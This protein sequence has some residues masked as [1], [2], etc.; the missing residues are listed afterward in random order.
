MKS[1]DSI[2][3]FYDRFEE[4]Q[5]IFA[6]VV[7]EGDKGGRGSRNLA[8]DENLSCKLFISIVTQSIKTRNQNQIISETFGGPPIQAGPWSVMSA[9]TR[10]LKPPCARFLFFLLYLSK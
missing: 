8:E 7:H 6:F 3:H 9:I 10:G 1:T 4:D 2:C 5:T